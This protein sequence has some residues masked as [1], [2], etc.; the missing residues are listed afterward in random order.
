ML[1]FL[2]LSTVEA[3]SPVWTFTSITPTVLNLAANGIGVVFYR[4]TNQSRKPHNLVMMPIVGVTQIPIINSCLDTNLIQ[5]G[6]SCNLLLLIKAKDVLNSFAQGPI[7]CQ[8][9]D[10]LQ[11]YQPS[12]SNILRINVTGK[13]TDYSI[14]GS[15]T[16]L[17]GTVQLTNNSIGDALTSSTDGAFTF[18]T[19]EQTGAPYDVTVL[20]QPSSQFCSVNGGTG[21]VLGSDVTNIQVTCNTNAHTVGGNI[22][23]LSGTVTLQNNGESLMTNSNGLFTFSNP[24]EKVVHIMSSSQLNRKIRPVPL[25]MVQGPWELLR[26]IM[27]LSPIAITHTLLVDKFQE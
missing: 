20:T 8:H 4:V 11:C 7:L 21:R 23:G 1:M 22:S 12:A 19:L 26:S 17:A 3:G 2:F 6:Q 24:V 9:G 5:Y 25:P 27:F 14:G 10:P 16:G 15:I 18:P 13:N